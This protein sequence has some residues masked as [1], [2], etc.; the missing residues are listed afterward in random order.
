MS[1]IAPASLAPIGKPIFADPVSIEELPPQD[2]IC[3]QKVAHKDNYIWVDA[4]PVFAAD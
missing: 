4:P 2:P 3:I 1:M